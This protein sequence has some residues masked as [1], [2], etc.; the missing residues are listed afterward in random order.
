MTPLLFVAVAL[1]GGLGATL[2]LVVDGVVKS[3]VRTTLPVGT[4]LIN[5]VG[6][7]LLGLITGLTLALWLPEAWHLVLGGGLLG[8]FTTFSTASYENVRL[9]QDRRSLPALV[10]GL[11]MLALAVGCAFL[12]LWLGLGG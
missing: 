11:G 4:L 10:N 3:R 6:S 9:A 7:L 1:A 5:V 2:R 12:G 8:G